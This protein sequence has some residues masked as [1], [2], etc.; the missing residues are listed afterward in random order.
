ME[1]NASTLKKNPSMI[2]A[3]DYKSKL[4]NARYNSFE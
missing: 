1:K 4:V 2:K 3:A